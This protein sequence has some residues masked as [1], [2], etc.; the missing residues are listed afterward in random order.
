MKYINDF[1]INKKLAAFALFLGVIAIFIGDPVKDSYATINTKDLAFAVAEKS[2]NI[3]TM[4]LAKWLIA[5]KA[6]FTLIDLRQDKKFNEY[7]IPGSL[8]IQANE[9]F[10]SKLM[11]NQKI[12]LYSDDNFQAAQAWLLLKAKNYKGVY[13]LKGGLEE[14]NKSILF[15]KLSDNATPAQKAEF[16]KIKYI[17]KYFGGNPITGVAESAE[18]KPQIAMPKPVASS[19]SA[20]P[21]GAKP[22]KEGC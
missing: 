18:Q 1:N 5:G 16:E 14:W 17:S 19:S 22:K 6:D 13:Q 20:T 8:N 4:E 15:P 7:H 3:E 2:A 11:K 21:K 10:K 9:L 12:I